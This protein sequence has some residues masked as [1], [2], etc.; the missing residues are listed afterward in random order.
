[1]ITGNGNQNR[2]SSDAVDTEVRDAL[3]P[4]YPRPE[5]FG[6]EYWRALETRIMS[7]LGG[8]VRTLEP[9]RFWGVLERWSRVGIAAAL[10]AVAGSAFVLGR[11]RA[12]ESSLVYESFAAAATPESVI[13]PIHLVVTQPDRAIQRDAVYRL[14]LSQ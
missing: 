14:I 1:M 10:L 12:R 8:S 13:D 9:A 6:A 3:R 11:A 2:V 4:L 5:S 7:Q